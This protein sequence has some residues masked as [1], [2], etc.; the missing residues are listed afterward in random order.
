MYFG[1]GLCLNLPINEVICSHMH[2]VSGHEPTSGAPSL[3]SLV[4][5]TAKSNIV[6]LKK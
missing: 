3:Y 2:P 5:L 1:L 6:V 4:Q